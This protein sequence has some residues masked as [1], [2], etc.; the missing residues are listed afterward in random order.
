M[1]IKIV[2]CGPPH[3]GKSVFLGGLCMNLLRWIFFLFRACPDGEGTWTWKGNGAEQYRRKGRFTQ[4][5]VDWYCR[6][7]ASC[8]MAPIVLVDI[9]GIPS[10]ENRR[11]L[12]EG[13]VSHG[14]ILAGDMEKVSEWRQ[15]LASC[16]V[17]VVAVLHSDYYG[18]EDCVTSDPM[19]VHHLERGD[20]SVS[21]RPAILAV[22]EKILK[23]TEE[24]TMSNAS[25]QFSPLTITAIADAIGKVATEKALPNGR[26]VKGI[27][28][29]GSDLPELAKL[30]H[31]LSA[32]MPEVVDIDG[33]GPAWLM[34]TLAHECHPRAVRLNSPDGYVG[35]GCQKPE[36]SGS[37]LDFTAKP[38]PEG[39][40][41][42]EYQLDPSRPM[43]PAELDDIAP[44]AVGMGDRVILSGRGPNWLMASLAMS[45]HG[46]CQAV[47]TFQPGTGS[48]V[49][50]T[51]TAGV[52]LG[53]LI[54]GN[55]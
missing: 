54:P 12:T 51:H 31:N 46:R 52:L 13:G 3:S 6:S 34:A 40:T 42:V 30:I 53:T 28:W 43:A 4:D 25:L 33:P 49:C 23:L 11:I 50:W 7:L 14:I 8:E 16:G 9:G 2:V 15:F 1:T 44:P 29:V 27:D 20:E 37:G 21:T 39:W 22:A 26:V 19:V 38:G 41:V 17:E 48:T 45:Y 18:T 47:A 10:E 5:V 32:S 24:V 55:V 36:G 35:V